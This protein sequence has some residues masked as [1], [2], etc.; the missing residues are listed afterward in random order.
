MDF[1]SFIFPQVKLTR[2]IGCRGLLKFLKDCSLF[3]YTRGC[4]RV[5]QMMQQNHMILWL[6]SLSLS[7]AS[8]FHNFLDQGLLT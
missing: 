6:K 5:G 4:I 8:Q 1:L 2:P 3:I 7:F